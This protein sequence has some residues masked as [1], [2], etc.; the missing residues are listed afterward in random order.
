MKIMTHVLKSSKMGPHLGR[1]LLKRPHFPHCKAFDLQVRKA[2]F[3]LWKHCTLLPVLLIDFEI[4]IFSSPGIEHGLS[5]CWTTWRAQRAPWARQLNASSSLLMNYSLL[6][7]RS[8]W[9]LRMAMQLKWCKICVSDART[10]AHGWHCQPSQE[11]CSH[12]K[13]WSISIL[14]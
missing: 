7:P 5:R 1:I 14:F 11:W 2:I 4:A 6:N 13:V 10:F 8:W 3:R 12:V 9:V